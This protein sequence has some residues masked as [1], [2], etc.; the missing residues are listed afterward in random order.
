MMRDRTFSLV[1]TVVP[2]WLSAAPLSSRPGT[3]PPGLPGRTPSSRPLTRQTHVSH[4]VTVGRTGQTAHFSADRDRSPP[5]TQ[6]TGTHPLPLD[7]RSTDAPATTAT[8][9]VSTALRKLYFLR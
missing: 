8:T 1:R 7:R 9:G 6:A 4:V 5:M 3:R 2:A